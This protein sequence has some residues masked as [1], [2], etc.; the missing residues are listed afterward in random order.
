MA[1]ESWLCLSWLFQA[2]F[3][4]GPGKLLVFMIGLAG[5][6]AMVCSVS[7]EKA[8]RV[9]GNN[10][11]RAKASMLLVGII[12][13]K[14]NKNLNLSKKCTIRR[15]PNDCFA[16]LLA[17]LPLGEI[18]EGLTSAVRQ[19]VISLPFPQTPL[20]MPSSLN[21]ASASKD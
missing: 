11:F 7:V 15:R 20:P 6:S 5:S 9:V 3:D 18:Q 12:N 17:P 13:N 1:L 19:G 14:T 4:S 21:T 2:S 16:R 10:A 8:R